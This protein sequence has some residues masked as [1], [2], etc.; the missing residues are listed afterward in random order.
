MYL[1]QII[2]GNDARFTLDDRFAKDDQ[3]TEKTELVEDIN[4]CDL[5]KEKERQLDI[6]ENILGE[7]LTH[8]VKDQ[9]LKTA[10]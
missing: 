7:P 2:L 8:I 10:K 9:E 5:Q 1:L 3:E 6:L 4:E